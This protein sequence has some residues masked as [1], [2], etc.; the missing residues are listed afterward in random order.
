MLRCPIK[1]LKKTDP[2]EPYNDK[3]EKRIEFH[4]FICNFTE[5]KAYNESN[6]VMLFNLDT[7]CDVSVILKSV[8]WDGGLRITFEFVNISVNIRVRTFGLMVPLFILTFFIF[9]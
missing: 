2:K 1:R 8:M 6:S 5:T 7:R 3:T 4:H 9:R